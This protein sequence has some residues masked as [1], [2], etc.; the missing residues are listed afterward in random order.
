MFAKIQKKK[1]ENEKSNIAYG[2]CV[3]GDRRS[4]FFRVGHRN[5]LIDSVFFPFKH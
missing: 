4:R 5:Q 3:H 2:M 1:K